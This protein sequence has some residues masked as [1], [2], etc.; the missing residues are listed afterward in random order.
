MSYRVITLDQKSDDWKAWRRDGIGASDAPIIL[1][2]SPYMKPRRLWEIKMG[3]APDN[4]MN[5]FVEERAQ[6][7]ENAA[8]A[9]LELEF[10]G[11]FPPVCLE[12]VEHPFIKASLDGWNKRDGVAMEAKY[13][14]AGK[15]TGKIPAH[16]WI[17]M[18]HQ[19]FVAD[20]PDIVYLR[21]SN[22]INF[23]HMIVS[24]DKAYIDMMLKEEINFWN[25]ILANRPPENT[26]RKAGWKNNFEEKI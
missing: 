5:A 7:V 26:R 16:H 18:Q 14:G 3:L 8:R 2:L 9:W 6:K 12:S 10:G 24:R 21:S 19:M 22:G 15:E 20:L 23:H 25:S 11:D 4:T 13:V 1:D 17:Q